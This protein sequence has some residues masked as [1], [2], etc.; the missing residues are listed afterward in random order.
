[1]IDSYKI[2]IVGSGAAGA[3]LAYK[4]S[5]HKSKP[6]ILVLEAGNNG[7]NSPDEDH[8]QRDRAR[9]VD[10][11]AL[12]VDRSSVAP[13]TRLDST[14]YAPHPTGVKDDKHLVQAGK[15]VF[16][17]NYGRLLG[18]STWLWRGN[19]PRMV[20]ADFEMFDRYGVG[21]NWPIRY[22]EVQ[23]DLNE[24]ERELGIAGDVGVWNE[25][26]QGPRKEPYPLPP[27][28]Q[29]LGDIWL[30]DTLEKNAHGKPVIDGQEI[31]VIPTPQAR[32]STADYQHP[33]TNL[34]RNQCQGNANCIPICPSGAKYDAA[35]HIRLAK[36]NGVTFKGSCPVTRVIKNEAGNVVGVSYRD[37]KANAKTDTDVRAEIV[38]LAANAIETPRLWLHSK[39]DNSRDLVGRNLMDHV[40]GDVVCMT[41][42]PIYPFRGPQNTSSI[43]SF[44]D[45]PKRNIV[46]SFNISVGNDGWGRF[47][48]DKG[49]PKGPFDIMDELL[50]DSTTKRLAAWGRDLQKKLATDEK[51]ALTHRL[52]LSY[53][54]EQLPDPANRVTLATETDALGIPRPKIEY[55]LSEYSARSLANARSVCRAIV[56]AAGRIPDGP[57]EIPL[58]YGGA[59][60]LMGTCRMGKNKDDS[61]VDSYGRSHAHPNLWVVGSSVFVTGSCVNP[62]VTLAGLT[63]RTAKEL[64]KTL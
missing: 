7:I 16:K 54:T 10:L 38:V 19:C 64:S 60:H 26:I 63:I 27:I 52:R 58:T 9:F 44:L 55:Q 57:D 11:Y 35:I 1:M 15:D 61:V 36:A 41:P 33:G 23:D 59:G 2:V 5:Q 21:A 18:G 6:L 39:L 51:T 32:I 42:V 48:D 13:Y 28:T 4:L 53:S 30:R 46:S 24:A 17:S 29:A 31:R 40:Q 37:M 34:I 20:P 50:W 56:R 25:A 43:T 22:D 62:T 49:K 47:V 12:N 8:T 45:H 3:L 14:R